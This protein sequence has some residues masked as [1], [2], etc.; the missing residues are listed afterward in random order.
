MYDNIKFELGERI[1]TSMAG[2]SKNWVNTFVS[3]LMIQR[4]PGGS[5]DE[6]L[7]SAQGVVPGFWD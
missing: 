6:C 7:P 4:C 2:F 5:A 3:K 1:L